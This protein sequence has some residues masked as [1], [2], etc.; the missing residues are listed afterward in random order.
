MSDLA[1]DFDGP[2]CD[3]CGAEMVWVEC[4][5]GCEDGEINMYDW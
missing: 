4:W 1:Y 2:C 3:K 5:R